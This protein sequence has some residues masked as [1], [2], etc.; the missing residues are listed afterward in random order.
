MAQVRL[1]QPFQLSYPG[2]QH[3]LGPRHG[4]QIPVELDAQVE[5]TAPG[6]D[7][8]GERKLHLLHHGA[9]AGHQLMGLGGGRG[10]RHGVVLE[11]EQALEQARPAFRQRRERLGAVLIE[12]HQIRLQPGY[13]LGQA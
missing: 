1:R 10:R 11:H 12:R 6:I 13:M 7:H 3:G 4:D 5:L 8:Q 2:G 9:K